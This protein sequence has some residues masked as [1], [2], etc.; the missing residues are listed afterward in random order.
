MT[1]T[2]P[3]D[4]KAIAAIC[5]RVP[6][7]SDARQ[8][9]FFK[10]V[11][12]SRPDIEDMLILGVYHGRDICFVQDILARY[13]P[14]RVLNIVG[15]DKFSNERCADWPGW[16][17]SWEQVTHGMPA[18]DLAAADRNTRGGDAMVTLLKMDDVY[19]LIGTELTYDFV[20]VDTSHDYQSVKNVLSHLKPVCREGATIA[21]D[22]FSNANGWGVPQAVNETFSHF[23]LYAGWIWVTEP[24]H[25]R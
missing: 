4:D 2:T 23:T 11:L 6:G 21:G 15:V 5:A 7:W 10:S 16:A 25:F 9:G 20:Y 12:A 19:F 1:M 24:K 3:E 18:P 17:G 8:Y 22:D 14:G 13:H